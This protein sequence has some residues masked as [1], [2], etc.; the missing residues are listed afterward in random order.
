MR[1]HTLKIAVAVAIGAGIT[2]ALIAIQFEWSV[3]AI[4]GALVAAGVFI[5]WAVSRPILGSLTREEP[6]AS[7]ERVRF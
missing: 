7:V 1:R 5:A 3:W 4:Y 2:L 6:Y